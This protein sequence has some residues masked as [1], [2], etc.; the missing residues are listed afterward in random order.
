MLIGSVEEKRGA[1]LFVITQHITSVAELEPV[2]ASTVKEGN[3]V[4]EYK[5]VPKKV[6]LC[7]LLLTYLSLGRVK[8]FF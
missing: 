7:E 6:F 8:K 4:L 5:F 1:T 3:F 2:G